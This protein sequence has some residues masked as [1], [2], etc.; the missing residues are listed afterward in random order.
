M[1]VAGDPALAGTPRNWGTWWVMSGGDE[2]SSLRA[3]D[4]AAGL[5]Q[6]VREVQ[7]NFTHVDR[8]SGHV[9]S[10]QCFLTADGKGM[11]SMHYERGLRCWVCPLDWQAN[12][13]LDPQYR[14][15]LNSIVYAT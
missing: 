14:S 4:L 8:Q 7:E 10:F 13:N 11:Q 1:D 12:L 6:Q 3:L 5:N 2:H 15:I 9:Y